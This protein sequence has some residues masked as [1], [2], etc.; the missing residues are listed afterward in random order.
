MNTVIDVIYMYDIVDVHAKAMVLVVKT[1]TSVV[2][3]DG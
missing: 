2:N 3:H 1:V